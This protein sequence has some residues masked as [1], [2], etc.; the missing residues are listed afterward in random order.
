MA[1]DSVKRWDEIEL[2]LG[3]IIEFSPQISPRG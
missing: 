2:P 1:V 3:Y